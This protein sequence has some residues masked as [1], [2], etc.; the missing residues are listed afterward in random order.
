MLACG[1][2]PPSIV[3]EERPDPGVD[4]TTRLVKPS[5]TTADPADQRVGS[6]LDLERPADEIADDPT[7][8][9][10]IPKQRADDGDR[11]GATPR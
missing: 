6:V 11:R 1:R 2:T 4:P 10:S 9:L 8:R 7:R 5:D 3:G